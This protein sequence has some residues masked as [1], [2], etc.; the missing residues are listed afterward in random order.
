MDEEEDIFIFS[1]FLTSNLYLVY[2]D[3]KILV[4]NVFLSF[5]SFDVVSETRGD[6]GNIGSRR[7]EAARLW[8]L[9]ARGCGGDD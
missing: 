1:I 8:R 4:K 7:N 6:M 3:T 2:Q 9:Y 5:G